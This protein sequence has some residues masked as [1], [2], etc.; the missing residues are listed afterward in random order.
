MRP[1]R[2]DSANAAGEYVVDIPAPDRHIVL[3]G[4]LVA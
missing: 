2:I 3:E 1:A 4:R